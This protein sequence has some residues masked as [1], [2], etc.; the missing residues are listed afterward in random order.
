[1]TSPLEAYLRANPNLRE[2][3]REKLIEELYQT[4][5]VAD[6]FE[7]FRTKLV[8]DPDSAWEREQAIREAYERAHRLGPREPKLPE[9][10]PALDPEKAP[11]KF[12]GE[13]PP[14]PLD[15][16]SA[17]PKSNALPKPPPPEPMAQPEGMEGIKQA[18]KT[19]E[20]LGSVV[21]G[22]TG[23]P[24]NPA[25]KAARGELPEQ[26]TSQMYFDEVTAGIGLAMGV[27]GPKF[28]RPKLG[29]GEKIPIPP[30]LSGR[31]WTGKALAN[32]RDVLDA[33]KIQMERARETMRVAEEQYDFEAAGAAK[34]ELQN[35]RDYWSRISSEQPPVGADMIMSRI[36]PH[37]DKP[38]SAVSGWWARQYQ[39]KIDRFSPINQAVKM[40]T[41][42]FSGSHVMPEAMDPYVLFRLMSGNVGRFEHAIKYGTFKFG[43][44]EKVGPGLRAII[45]PVRD[46]VDEAVRYAVS[47]RVIESE[48]QGYA[49]GMDLTFAKQVVADVE[50]RSAYESKYAGIVKFQN[51]WTKFSRDWVDYLVDAGVY[52]R[53]TANKFVTRNMFYLPAYRL[54]PEYEQFATGASKSAAQ[55]IKGRKGSTLEWLDPLESTIKNTQAFIH[56]AERNNAYFWLTRMAETYN[57]PQVAQRVEA[58]SV[59]PI[60]LSDS[61]IK[62]LL[63]DYGVQGDAGEGLTIFRQSFWR[64]SPNEIVVMN[65]GE[66]EVWRVDPAIAD[67]INQM[68]RGAV[69]DMTRMFA[70]PARMLRAGATRS[71][72]FPVANWWRDQMSAMWNTK[73]GYSPLESWRVVADFVTADRSDS[74]SFMNWLKSPAGGNMLVEPGEGYKEAM[75]AGATNVNVVSIDEMR[76]HMAK[77]GVRPMSRA[78]VAKWW[79]TSPM[80][81][82]QLWSNMT[83]NATRLGAYLKA[84]SA[85][86]SPQAA[87]Y[88]FR[89]ITVDFAR[90]GAQMQAYNMITSFQ[91]AQTQGVDRAIRGAMANPQRAATVAV[92]GNL[93]PAVL[94][95]MANHDD[96]RY[97]NLQDY[98]RHN[99][100]IF[101]MDDWKAIPKE[102]S[103]E[104]WEKTGSI[105]PEE[106]K[107][108]SKLYPIRVNSEGEYEVNKGA[109]ANYYDSYRLRVGENGQWEANMGAVVKLPM[110]WEIGV[111]FASTPVAAL[112][113]YVADNPAASKGIINALIQAYA[114]NFIPTALAAP[115]EVA[116]DY[117]FFLGRGITPRTLKDEEPKYRYTTYT[118]ETAK[119]FVAFYDRL[120][121]TGD[122]VTPVHVDYLVRGWTGQLGKYALDFS[123]WALRKAG[124]APPET[125]AE[126]TLANTPVIK[127][128]IAQS[129]S[130]ANQPIGEFYDK[131]TE[132]KQAAKSFETRSRRGEKEEAAQIE[133]DQKFAKVDPYSKALNNIRR[134]IDYVQRIPLR[135]DDEPAQPGDPRM[136]AREKTALIEEDYRQM[137]VI[138]KE[139]TALMEAGQ[140]KIPAKSRAS[141]SDDTTNEYLK[142]FM[143]LN[144]ADQEI[145]LNRRTP[146]QRWEMV[147]FL[148]RNLQDRYLSIWHSLDAEE[149]QQIIGRLPARVRGWYEN[150]PD[151]FGGVKGRKKPPPPP[152]GYSPKLPT[153]NDQLL[154]PDEA[155][156]GP[157]PAAAPYKFTPSWQQ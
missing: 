6:E 139:G 99:Y 91:N 96:P 67:A 13:R 79:A 62:Q 19:G 156:L 1:M 100:F 69:N 12:Y 77:L 14:T 42:K 125:R 120:L 111:T 145:V 58:K 86:A 3:D 21:E 17:V 137:I 154:T 108:L 115:F 104:G 113:K 76:A 75:R 94:L 60:D 8:R 131:Y 20:A 150:L 98:E 151:D 56:I 126:W 51:Q 50:A 106:Y 43:T 121:P 124:V 2:T 24:V 7:D 133:R 31:E 16:N 107:Q 36:V 129:P 27:L 103:S 68:D 146:I 22:V 80:A 119:K 105:K 4:S 81:G 92:G 84:R 52:S 136:T 83:E 148:R 138:A 59:R 112:N 65:K 88:E 87:A 18:E 64:P 53:E 157:P 127:R 78:D 46:H 134:H 11:E 9:A 72:D 35:L 10:L 34:A 47:K 26:D 70:L 141:R 118:S 71:P 41:G 30:W 54:M 39:G 101:L 40:A 85:G 89:E 140:N 152:P 74:L 33:T 116:S 38:Q 142:S 95:W 82:L 90:N 15:Q 45:N 23:L 61:E 143:N 155:P 93:I 44:Y 130:Y 66:R 37:P 132:M 135:K 5:G 109:L 32:Y 73:Y 110:A 147:P 97:K 102:A 123:D 48:G 49:T 149:Q 57:L 114:P 144:N 25:I 29:P 55:P 153:G 122:V 128:F 63:S 28:F 117:S